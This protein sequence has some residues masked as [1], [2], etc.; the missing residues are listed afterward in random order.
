MS[1]RKDNRSESSSGVGLLAG[2]IGVGIGLLAGF[3]YNK[4][5]SSES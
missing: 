5:T 4:L 2:A 1:R 3:V